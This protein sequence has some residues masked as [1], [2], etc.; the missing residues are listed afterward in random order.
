MPH[1][2]LKILKF[3]VTTATIKGPSFVNV[4]DTVELHNLENPFLMQDLWP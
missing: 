4:N 3:P 2:V 1:F